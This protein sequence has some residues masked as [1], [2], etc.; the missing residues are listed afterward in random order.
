MLVMHKFAS[1]V[2]EALNANIV[3]PNDNAICAVML[4]VAR[5]DDDTPLG[6]SLN[7]DSDTKQW[8]T[9]L[10]VSESQPYID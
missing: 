3:T 1:D 8:L 10:Q 4:I 2:T 7:Y 5:D 9:T 6:A